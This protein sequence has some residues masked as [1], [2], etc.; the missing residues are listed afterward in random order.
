MTIPR[1]VPLPPARGRLVAEAGSGRIM[2][3]CWEAPPSPPLQGDYCSHKR[4]LHSWTGII[5]SGQRRG[6]GDE[7][8]VGTTIAIVAIGMAGIP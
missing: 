4:I 3:G 2:A 5:N 7:V 8:I 1:V 6:A